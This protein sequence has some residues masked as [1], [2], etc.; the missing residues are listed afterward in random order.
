MNFFCAL[1]NLNQHIRRRAHGCAMTSTGDQNTID[2]SRHIYVGLPDP[3]RVGLPA[4]VTII[5][6]FLIAYFTRGD[7]FDHLI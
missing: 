2:Q 4:M 1:V 5:V 6:D 3:V 7:F